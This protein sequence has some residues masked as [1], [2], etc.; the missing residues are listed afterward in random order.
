[1]L[2]NF[3]IKKTFYTD[4]SLVSD[5][6]QKKKNNKIIINNYLEMDNSRI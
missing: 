5:E 4:N 2:Y 3:V 1:M 6:Q